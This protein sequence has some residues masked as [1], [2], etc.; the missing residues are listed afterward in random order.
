MGEIQRVIVNYDKYYQSPIPSFVFIK[1]K[2]QI[3]RLKGT[4]PTELG[5]LIEKYAP[6]EKEN[7]VQN[8]EVDEINVKYTSI[9][10]SKSMNVSPR[11]K[12]A[13][14]KPFKEENIKNLIKNLPVRS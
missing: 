4:K 7:N 9:L 14:S 12:E 8:S 6:N 5:Q 13:K 2:E 10:Q 1:N 11:K 3:Y